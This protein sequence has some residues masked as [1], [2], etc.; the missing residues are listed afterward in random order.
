MVL[1]RKAKRS[2]KRTMPL[3][4][5]GAF[6]VI[7]AMLV[8]YSKAATIAVA[9][10]A[11]SGTLAGNAAKVAPSAGASGNATIAFG[12]SGSS[13]TAPTTS[14]PC[15]VM[16]APSQYKHVIWIWEENKDVGNVTGNSSAPYINSLQK[17]C[18]NANNVLDDA[19][20]PSYPSEPSYAVATAGTNCN[21]NGSGCITDDNDNHAIDAVSIFQLAKSSGGSWKS[22]QESMPSNCATSSSGDYGFKHNPAA[23]YSQIRTDCKTLDVSMPGIS[24]SNSSCGTPSGVFVNDIR[25]GSLPTFAFVTPNLQ[26]DMHDGSVQQGDSWIKTYMPLIINGPN[27]Q[28]GDTAVF[29]MWDEGSSNSAGVKGIPS[30]FVAPSIPAGTTVSTAT[31]NVGI[32]KTTQEMLGLTPLL[33]CAA[34]GNGC[35]AHS[36]VSIRAAMHL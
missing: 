14:K 6:I 19:N 28:A 2:I 5:A 7:G 18:G 12:S 11:E 34:G 10:E 30:V 23:F 31:N 17:L 33:G 24:C 36:S 8:V 25:N 29:V 15:G 9:S 32:L 20:N 35:Q 27:Y 1:K 3:V 21:T 4:V 13:D 16:S 22:Y 26:N